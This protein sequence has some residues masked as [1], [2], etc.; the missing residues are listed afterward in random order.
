MNAQ[1][2]RGLNNKMPRELK[3]RAWDEEEKKMI[4]VFNIEFYHQEAN[5]YPACKKNLFNNL[6]QFTG[7]HDRNGNEIFENDII[8]TVQRG[9]E[10]VE[11]FEEYELIGYCTTWERGTII[12]N[13][14]QHPELLK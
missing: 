10:I 14:H 7:L 12:G 9:I 5:H 6:M 13:I 3:F 11:L 4:E 2:R 1:E 8:D